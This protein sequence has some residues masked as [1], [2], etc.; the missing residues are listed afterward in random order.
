MKLEHDNGYN[1]NVTGARESHPGFKEETIFFDRDKMSLEICP[2]CQGGNLEVF[3]TMQRCYNE[4][5][6]QGRIIKFHAESDEVQHIE[7]IA[8]L[9][10][11][12]IWFV[13][14]E[15]PQP[16]SSNHEKRKRP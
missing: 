16:G 5:W 12:I 10:C 7:I 9:T 2:H 14:Y 13:E 15:E 8:C 11:E 1:P 6:E 4:D 3:G